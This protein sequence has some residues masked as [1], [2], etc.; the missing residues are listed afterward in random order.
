MEPQGVVGRRAG[1]VNFPGYSKAMRESGVVWNERSLRAFLL[2]TNG[3]IPGTNMV[4]S[5]S[6]SAADI[7]ALVFYLMHV[8][9]AVAAK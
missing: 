2:N 7:G 1:S 9:R 6:Q 4:S 8:T 3:F 5:G